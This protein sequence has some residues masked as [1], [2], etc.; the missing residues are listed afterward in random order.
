MAYD[1]AAG[2]VRLYRSV[3][4]RLRLAG[5]DMARTQALAARYASPAFEA[6]LSEQVLNYNQG[7]PAATFGPETAVGYLIIAA[8]AYY[9]AMLPFMD[10]RESRGFDVT[11]VRCSEIPAAALPLLRSRPTSRMRTT[12]GLSL[13]AMSCW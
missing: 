6:R 1:P 5:S 11:M 8:D 7:R 4:F 3:T 9:D 2:T 12:P 13:P 10:L